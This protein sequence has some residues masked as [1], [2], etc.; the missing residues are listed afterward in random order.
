[1]KAHRA[2]LSTRAPRAALSKAQLT[3][4]QVPLIGR[5]HLVVRSAQVFDLDTADV[6]RVYWKE[7]RSLSEPATKHLGIEPRAHE[8]L[9]ERG[10]IETVESQ[11]PCHR[12]T[13]LGQKVIERGRFAPPIRI[14]KRIVE[15]FRAA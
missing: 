14:R 11:R 4:F 7:L 3:L 2:T 1:M 13:R 15:S 5:L 9:L 10:L 6:P 12:V 8:W